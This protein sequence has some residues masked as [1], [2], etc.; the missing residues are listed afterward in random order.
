MNSQIISIKF[1]YINQLKIYIL[2]KNVLQQ[3]QF[4]EN[5]EDSV[6]MNIPKE[7]YKKC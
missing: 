6:K 2:N 3:S 4:I 1:Y 7:N 5:H